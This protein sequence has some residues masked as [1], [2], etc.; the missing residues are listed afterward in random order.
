M[1]IN[2]VRDYNFS[3]TEEEHDILYQAAHI[4]YKME[5]AGGVQFFNWY[6]NH[7]NYYREQLQI[8]NF[9]AIGDLLRDIDNF[10]NTKSED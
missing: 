6:C 10:A 5:T 9:E 4:L 3:L 7:N 1:I 2:E 8:D